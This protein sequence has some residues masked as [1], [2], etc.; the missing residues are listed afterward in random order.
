MAL[1]AYDCYAFL[2]HG[3]YSG[4]SREG[5]VGFTAAE[6]M[7]RIISF[8]LLESAP[9]PPEPTGGIIGIVV[10]KLKNIFLHDDIVVGG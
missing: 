9:A 10:G 5:D 6:R 7:T 3:L 8:G 2:T 4:A 1:S